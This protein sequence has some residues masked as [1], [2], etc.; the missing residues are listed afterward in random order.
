MGV[1][2]PWRPPP[3]PSMGLDLI[4]YVTFCFLLTILK[5]DFQFRSYLFVETDE[6][7]ENYSCQNSI[8][9]SRLFFLPRL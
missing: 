9:I 8:N 2:R 3:D 7:E 5:C 1:R 6:G 4:N